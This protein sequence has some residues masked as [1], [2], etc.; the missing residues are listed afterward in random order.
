MFH[1]QVWQ[2]SQKWKYKK[3]AA[4][5]GSVVCT[6]IFMINIFLTS[7]IEIFIFR[8][9][10]FL[11]Y[12]L[13]TVFNNICKKHSTL[14]IVHYD[15]MHSDFYFIPIFMLNVYIYVWVYRYLIHVIVAHYYCCNCMKSL[16][17]SHFY[18]ILVFLILLW[19]I[20]SIGYTNVQ[21]QMAPIS[22]VYNY[23]NSYSLTLNLRCSVWTDTG[24]EPLSHICFMVST[25]RN[26]CDCSN[27]SNKSRTHL[28]IF[29]DCPFWGP[30]ATWQIWSEK[31]RE[32]Q[33]FGFAMKIYF[34][35]IWIIFLIE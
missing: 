31:F 33:I 25:F 19:P 8:C 4:L 11:F 16:F 23:T 26:S 14:V 35:I 29:L 2:G 21:I 32:G 17:C 9:R 24:L 5:A 15:E 12:T 18:W 10:G 6:S 20:L 28:L 34:W 1:D 27:D 13:L 30:S 3:W 7:Q 22:P